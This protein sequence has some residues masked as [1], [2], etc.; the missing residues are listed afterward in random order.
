MN[1]ME[2]YEE[3]ERSIIKTYRKNI[4]R[5]F[6]RGINDYKMINAGDK[7]AV[8]LS[9]GADSA[10]MAKC[11][12]EI[13][14]HGVVKFELEFITADTG[15]SDEERAR[16]EDNAKTLNIPLEI[17][18]GEGDALDLLCEKAKSLGCNKIALGHHFDDVIEAI[19]KNML[20]GAQIATLMPKEK[21]AGLEIIRPLYMIKSKDILAWTRFNGLEFICRP[22]RDEEI[23]E[24]IKKFRRTSPYIDMN[25]FNSVQ[26]VNL[27]TVIAYKGKGKEYNFLEDYDERGGANV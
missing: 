22:P 8:C 1:A 15:F 4:W 11:A 9:G 20:R 27:T 21:Y 12:Q 19:L 18:S 5:K 14:R 13:H 17:F 10:V 24:L 26:D 23:K 16:I 25:I 2:R 7:I 6:I 3:I